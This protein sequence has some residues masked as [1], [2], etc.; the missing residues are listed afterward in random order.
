M[1][2]VECVRGFVDAVNAADVTRMC[3]LMTEDHLFVDSDGAEVRGRESMRRSWVQYFRMMSHYHIEV[4]ETF[5]EAGTV[6]LVGTASGAC[7]AD[8]TATAA[9]HWTVPAAW[10][11]VVRD[12][13]VAVWQVFVN[14]EPIRRAMHGS[15]EGA[16][17][18]GAAPDH[19]R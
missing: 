8:G 15:Q 9:S 10:R 13:R 4:T 2:I 19:R 14:P 16:V 1:T 11:A 3:T 5:C 12:G 17:Q 6:I 18:P 7:A